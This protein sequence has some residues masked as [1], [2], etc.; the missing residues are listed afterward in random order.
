MATD[1]ER[2]LVKLEADISK[3]EK[4]MSRA[5]GIANKQSKQ[6]EDSFSGLEKRLGAGMGSAA[7]RIGGA[8]A[9][10]FSAR[11]ILQAADTYTKIQNALKVTGLAGDALRATY[12]QL[13]AAAQRQGAPLDATVQLYSRL[14]GAQRDLNAT[15]GE[16][17]QFTE[18]V[19]LA[20]RVAGTSASEASGAL[21]QLGQ[22]LGGGK[23]Q[24]EEY[25]SLLDGARP[26]LQAV[27]I[28]LKEAGGSVS[29]L[30][31]L[32]KDGKVSSEAFFRAF[33]AGMP[34]LEAQAATSAT[35]IGQATERVQ[36]AFTNLIG[37]FD[38]ATSVSGS[39]ASA[40]VGVAGKID[41]IAN[42]LPK[43]V[44]ALREFL[45]LQDQVR[46]AGDLG[47]T[48]GNIIG[49]QGRFSAAPT[50][51]ED[52]F[53][54][55]VQAQIDRSSRLLQERA[56]AAAAGREENIGRGLNAMPRTITPVSLA[57]YPV[58]D[59][60]KKGGGGGGDSANAY[61]RE[62]QQIQKRTEALKLEAETIGQSQY[63]IDQARVAQELMNA[64][65]EA[66][67]EI[68]PQLKAQIDQLSASY[69][70]AKQ[71]T[72]AAAEAQKR[73]NEL[74]TFAGQTLS[75]FFSDIV[76]GGKNAS[77]ALMN[78]TKKL[79]D[80][81]IQA[82][83]LGQGP[84]AGLFNTKGENG[85]VGGLIGALISG[86]KAEGGPVAAGRA[87]VVG[88]KGPEIMVPGRSGMVV[89]NDIVRRADAGGGGGQVIHISQTF[90]ADANPRELAA[91][92]A[93]IKAQTMAAV[94]DATARG[95]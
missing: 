23:V 8:L 14:A 11:E 4:A 24:A 7:A 72:E 61:E 75:G 78:L 39:L 68:T 93:T 17:L 47:A 12:D 91:I 19:G 94:R 28:G 50:P 2:L 90:T 46:A 15:Q 59:D 80:A 51:R 65:K 37:K 73:M 62:I 45:L 85:A 31:K 79:A 48:A 18:G 26:L 81:A 66:G 63:A 55:A 30:T 54:P 43:G 3:Y 53:N 69:A 33:L 36:N 70:A 5:G 49:A 40:L 84:L 57:T 41:D 56:R 58:T 29:A 32:V 76:S 82:L 38:E 34:T 86:F 6:I 16:L 83:L 52:G 1:L 60:K 95:R 21:L 67:L 77:E 9:G 42:A 64:A 44:K 25:N 27:A 13:Y 87:Y 88:E 35:T 10:A 20:L 71:T 89:P 74:A 22:A 92:A